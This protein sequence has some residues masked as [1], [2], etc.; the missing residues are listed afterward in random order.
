MEP[1][2]VSTEFARDGTV[3]DEV[4]NALAILT[5]DPEK[6]VRNVYLHINAQQPDKYA[7]PRGGVFEFD[8]ESFMDTPDPLNYTWCGQMLFTPLI[9]R[10]GGF[11]DTDF[12]DKADVLQSRLVDQPDGEL[13]PSFDHMRVEHGTVKDVKPWRAALGNHG[14][15]GI[16]RQERDR[17]R[18]AD[19]YWLGVHS[20]APDKMAYAFF[21]KIQDAPPHTRRIGEIADCDEYRI[22]LNVARRNAQRL[23]YTTAAALGVDQYLPLPPHTDHAAKTRSEWVA[24]PLMAPA[25][26]TSEYNVL[27][28][29][30]LP[31]VDEDADPVAQTRYY[32]YCSPTHETT[33]QLMFMHS[34]EFGVWAITVPAR[35][36]SALGLADN[37][38]L[39]SWPIGM[40]RREVVPEDASVRTHHLLWAGKTTGV[41]HPKVGA[42]YEEF[43][44]ERDAPTLSKLA[45][46]D[47]LRARDDLR[48]VIVRLA[49]ATDPF[50]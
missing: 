32:S 11:R 20:A 18:G 33:G 40:P 38:A 44:N 41:P 47:I 50:D 30:T 4:S 31:P 48:P 36:A 12:L 35:P 42:V 21:K 24:L 23:L 45:G 13:V 14:F 27:Q 9:D 28:N 43:D 6:H 1:P 10:P 19:S 8:P 25:P 29:I 26:N 39:N 34:P 3:P 49:C 16:F 37:A 7:P 17:V 5:T 46:V 15:V 2:T 22:L